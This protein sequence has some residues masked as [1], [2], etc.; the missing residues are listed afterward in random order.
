MLMLLFEFQHQLYASSSIHIPTTAP[1]SSNGDDD[2]RIPLNSS[3][4]AG[5]ESPPNAKAAV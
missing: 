4:A 5:G 2:T 1:G 3:V